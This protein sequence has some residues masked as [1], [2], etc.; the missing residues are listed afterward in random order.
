M[1]T[2]RLYSFALRCATPIGRLWLRR[3]P[4]H[5]PLL[6]RFAPRVP[7]TA[8]RAVWIHAC[9]LGE[10]N[11]AQPLVQELQKT[12][13]AERVAVSASTISGKERA[14]KLFGEDGTFFCPFDTPA[15]VD[16][17]LDELRPAALVLIDTE[18]WPN[19][20]LGCARRGIP[21][22]VIN[23]RLSDRHFKKYRRLRRLFRPVFEK[24]NGVYVQTD[25]YAD[26]FR[27]LG[28]RPERVHVTGSLK[29]DAVAV[30]ADRSARDRLRR[31]CGIPEQ[32][33]VLVFGSTRPGDERL[34]SACWSTLREEQPEL[35]LIVALRHVDRATETT[36][37][38]D[39]PVLLR[40]SV[41]AG[42]APQGERV[43]LVDTLGELPHFYALADVAV[44]G[45]SF[46]PGV[47]GHNPL[48]PAALGIP[49]VFGPYMSNFGEPAAV[50]VAARGAIQVPCAEDL[51]GVLSHLLAQPVE[52]RNI[53]TRARK[54]VLDR[55][56]AVA[57]NVAAIL[58]HLPR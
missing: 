38:F 33:P 9:S 26:R 22:L 35:R 39:E 21:V 27:A 2:S 37:F 19:L 44:V 12:L 15:A 48:E 10:V 40:S 41:Q 55:R 32:A 23:G 45:G 36:A 47:E 29:Y 53:G 51:Y 58:G 4:R 34:A 18:I 25:L 6:E 50:L 31:A 16:H 46:Y 8:A 5:A 56:G 30:E 17:T 11:A 42:R 24:L 20:I 13:G 57:R 1:L 54:A 3:Q 28:C 43:I 14:T 7:Q 49:A 52:A